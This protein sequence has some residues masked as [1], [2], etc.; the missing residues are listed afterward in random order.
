[1]YNFDSLS[2]K[3]FLRINAGFLVNASIQKIQQ[4]SRREIIL[5]LRANG[6]SR[7][8]YININ[9]KY[10]HICF[11][12]EK[13]FQMRALEI[14]KSPP[15]FCMQLR[16][17]LEGSRIKQI[18]IPDYERILELHF[19]VY[20]ETGILAKLCLAIEI[21]GRHS[22]IILYDFRSKII[23][24]SAHN[25]SAQK[26]SVRE[27]RGGIPYIYPPVQYK[28]DILKTS[29]GA[30]CD[31][32]K[33][34]PDIK[35]ALCTH[36]YLLSAPLCGIILNKSGSEEELFE[37]L[38]NTL[39]LKDTSALL[40]LWGGDDFNSALDEY[41]ANIMYDDIFK[42]KKAALERILENEIKKLSNIIKNPPEKDKALVY[43]Q[44]GDGIFQYIYLIKEGTES[45]T[46]PEGLEISLDKTLTPAQ[47]AKNYY[48]LY[49]KAK[50]AYEYSSQK[51]LE[52]KEKKEYFEEILFSLQNASSY[53]ELDEITSELIMCSLVKKDETKKQEKKITLTKLTFGGYEILLGKNNR[54]N[55]YLISKASSA[56]DIWLHAYNCPSSHVLIKVKNDSLPPPPSVLEFAAKLVK[57]NSPMKNSGKVSIIYTKRKNLKKPPGGVPGYVTYKNEKEIVI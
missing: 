32:I 50:G 35:G 4:P 49:S 34:S 12:N 2:L 55:D 54:Q 57:E 30:F 5:N 41:F 36:Y 3:N 21:M 48:K 56:E 10:P 1:M 26:S 24:G 43:K 44:Y 31:V 39:S 9:P 20:D 7:K 33:N 22:N 8:L 38:Q 13:T 52:A 45:F 42:N 6:E 17:Y 15:M 14:P 25:I 29:Y 16:K 23:L 51:Y 19:E 18:T 47:N 27:I 53:Q 37:N 11:I 40:E 28:T 46:T